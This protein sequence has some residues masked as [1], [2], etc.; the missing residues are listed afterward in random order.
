MPVFLSSQLISIIYVQGLICIWIT[1]KHIVLVGRSWGSA[2]QGAQA[3][4]AY[5]KAKYKELLGG[6][7]PECKGQ[8]LF[9]FIFLLR[10]VINVY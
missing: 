8:Q 4:Q 3:S 10:L 7:L 9:I 6:K 1:P 2:R 5:R